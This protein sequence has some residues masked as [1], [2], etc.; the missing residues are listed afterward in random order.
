MPLTLPSSRSE[1]ENFLTF[2]DE[3]IHPFLLSQE[4]ARADAVRKAWRYGLFFLALSVVMFFVMP[5][6][7]KIILAFLSLF[8]GMI[9]GGAIVGKVGQKISD[10]LFQKITGHFGYEY[11]SKLD[12]PEY[13]N[14]FNDLS[15]FEAFNREHWEDEI[16]GVYGGRD[17][18]LCEAHLKFK[19]SGKNSSTR[20]VFHGQLLSLSYPKKFLGTTVLR[21]DAGMM[22]RFRKPAKGFKPVGISSPKFEA[23]FEAWSTDQVE[24]RALLDPVVLERFQELDRIFEGKGVQAAFVN[25]RLIMTVQTGDRLNMGSMFKSIEGKERIENIIKEFDIIFDLMDLAIKPAE[26]RL[27]GAIS[28][29]QLKK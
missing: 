1:F 9:V 10:T 29:D 11:R 18:I 5:G 3:D 13:F 14:L 21:R 28:L 20:T 16:K 26:G 23:I 6:D 8:T 19:I 22:N 7:F 15:M 4:K 17:F 2:Y 25:G 24:A 27:T 12:R